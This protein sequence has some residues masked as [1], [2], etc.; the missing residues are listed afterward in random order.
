MYKRQLYRKAD[1]ANSCRYLGM[2]AHA[3]ETY[4]NQLMPI[5]SNCY[6]IHHCNGIYISLPYLYD[7]YMCAD[8]EAEYYSN[9]ILIGHEIIHGFDIDGSLYDW[10]G[11][12]KDWWTP[13]DRE[14]FEALCKRVED[15]YNR[16]ECAPGLRCNGALNNGEDVADMGGLRLAL[17]AAGK[18]AEFDYDAFFRCY[19]QKFAL[20]F[21]RSGFDQV[22][23]NDPHAI[24][25][26]RIN[27]LYAL[28]DEFYETYGIAEGDGMYV[29]P[30]ER[31]RVW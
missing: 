27:P 16:T 22:L 14:R 31:V 8:S 13:E 4:V 3:L 29:P 9:A 19:A 1:N 11:E 28:V 20:L 30:D 12:R 21:S 17:S 6:A 26:V 7:D 15:Y 25:R 10:Q 23:Y 18:K 2:D 5:A 24:N